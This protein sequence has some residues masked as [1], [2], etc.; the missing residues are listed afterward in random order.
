MDQREAFEAWAQDKWE[1]A[2]K[3][4]ARRPNGSYVYDALEFAWAAWQA[5]QYATVAATLPDSSPG[6]DRGGDGG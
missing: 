2:G 5:A 4:F 1:G 6:G 3:T